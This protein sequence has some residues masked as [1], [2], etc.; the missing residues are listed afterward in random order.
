[1]TPNAI[2]SALGLL[3]DEWSL[4]LV[5]QSLLGIRRFSAFQ[6]AL[7]IGPAVLSARL[8][9]LVDGGVLRKDD[10]G[11]RLTAA[12]KELWA[13]LLCIWAWE[14][15]WVQGES[16]PAMRHLTCG[17]VFAPAL[18]CTSCR[19]P[20]RWEDVEIALGPSGDL[21]RAVPV[22]RNR[23]RAGASR[24]DG[25]ALFPETMTLMGSRWS[26]ALLGCCFLGARR[27]RDFETML[28]AP[29]TIVSERLRTF[30]ALG[31]LDDGYALTAKG[32]DF[33]PA[34]V[35]L[36]QWGERWH[37]APDGPAL[38]ARH[39]SCG[40][41]FVPDLR[42]NACDEALN[43]SAVMIEP[44]GARHAALTQPRPVPALPPATQLARTS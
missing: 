34:V 41:P 3:G 29:P 7:G 21:S 1:V 39:R 13:L 24:P 12:G 18:A 16:L 5:Q 4:L 31:V 20:T 2:G 27:F 19:A 33:F 44:P 6:A 30:V 36:V 14:Q 32:R 23:R 22:G 10:D 38:L 8:T 28:G 26:S 11:Y 9:A 17:A 25:P 42:C 40:A 15:Q 37:P 43:R 35:Q